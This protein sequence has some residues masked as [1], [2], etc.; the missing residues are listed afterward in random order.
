MFARDTRDARAHRKSRGALAPS[1]D[2]LATMPVVD[3]DAYFARIGW[4]GTRDA[5]AEVLAGIYAH[6][7]RAIPFENL[8]VLLGRRVSLELP[9]LEA[10]LVHARRGGYCYEHASLFAAVLRE[11]GF[12][13]HLHSARV[14][15]VT[16][17]TASPRTHMFVSVG[18]L[19]LDPGFGGATPL[20]PV[21][22]DGTRAGEHRLVRDGDVHALEIAKPDG[23][24]QRLWVSTLERDN[25]VDFEMANHFTSTH[26]SSPFTQRLMARVLTADGKVAIMNR[27]VTIVRGGETQ[28]FQL[29]DRAALH[30]L[31]A[32]HFAIDLPELAWLRIPSVADWG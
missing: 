28:T 7:V 6:H 24:W 27:D 20:E 8:D 29:A 10:K 14:V 26:P 19:V 11:L 25:P 2:L 3:L 16:P 31:F 4:R 21:P 30:Q 32:T 17:R 18:E 1:A 9:A 22:L 13:V 23:S 15:M 5:S 12:T